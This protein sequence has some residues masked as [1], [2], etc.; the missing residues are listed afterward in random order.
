[1]KE[2]LALPPHYKEM[3]QASMVKEMDNLTSQGTFVAVPVEEVV[4]H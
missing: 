4:G 2:L 1:M 3:W